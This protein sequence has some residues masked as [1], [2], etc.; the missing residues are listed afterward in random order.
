MGWKSAGMLS[1]AK[2]IER[3]FWLKTKDCS[4][5]YILE[6]NSPISGC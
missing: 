6:E 5:K 4:G 2:N 1:K 3:V